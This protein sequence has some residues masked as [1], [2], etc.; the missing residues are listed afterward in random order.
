VSVGAIADLPETGM[1]ANRN[2]DARR[3]G[4]KENGQRR[5]KEGRKESVWR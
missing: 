3:V 5:E 4:R 2:P 1:T